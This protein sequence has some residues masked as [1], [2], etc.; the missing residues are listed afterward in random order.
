M[1]I[2][3]DNWKVT[4]MEQR[5]KGLRVWQ[6]PFVPL[7]FPKLINLRSEPFERAD[8][9]ASMYDDKWLADRMFVFVP[10]QAAVGLFLNTFEEFPPRQKPSSFSIGEALEKAR[11]SE[12]KIAKAAVAA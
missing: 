8:E 7:R 10:A 1:A 12:M 4:F 5:A 11:S 3:V 2:H 9:D 6:E